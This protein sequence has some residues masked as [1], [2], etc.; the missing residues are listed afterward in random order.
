[1]IFE[2]MD[3]LCNIYTQGELFLRPRNIVAGMTV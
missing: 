1:M 3:V 2:D